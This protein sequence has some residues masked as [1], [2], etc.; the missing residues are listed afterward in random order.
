MSHNA[1][2]IARQTSVPADALWFQGHFPGDPMLPGI[3]QLH[4][5]LEAIK[6]HLGEGVRLTGLKRVRFKRIIRPGEFIAI[7]AEPVPDKAGLFRFG[8]TVEG[9]NACSGLM[10]T[11]DVDADHP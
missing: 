4:L 5:V 1:A 8:L 3:A 2:P 6:A 11:D 9:E 7:T 10:L